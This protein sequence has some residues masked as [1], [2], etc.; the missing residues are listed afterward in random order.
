MKGTGRGFHFHG[1]GGSSELRDASGPGTFEEYIME[2]AAVHL[3]DSL[4][5]VSR[6]SHPG[7]SRPCS[8]KSNHPR[9]HC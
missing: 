5:I 4:G 2:I 8:I 7:T 9:E 3:K 6:K 1:E